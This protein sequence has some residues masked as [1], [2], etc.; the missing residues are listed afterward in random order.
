MDLTRIST[1]AELTE[2]FD[3][4]RGDRSYRM[5]PIAHVASRVAP[6]T[7]SRRSYAAGATRRSGGVRRL[8]HGFD[9]TG[10]NFAEMT[11]APSVGHACPAVP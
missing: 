4:L 10:V 7:T 1:V 3:R 8:R 5:G 11:I 2:D 6:A 9:V